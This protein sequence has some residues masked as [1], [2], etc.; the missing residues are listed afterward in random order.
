LSGLQTLLLGSSFDFLEARLVARFPVRPV[1]DD[2]TEAR[3]LDLGE[4]S[5]RDLRAD[6]ECLGNSI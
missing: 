3:L 1:A 4:I 6:R 5:R 2:R